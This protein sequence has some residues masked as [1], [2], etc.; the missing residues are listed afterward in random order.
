LL[1][2]YPLDDKKSSLL[3]ENGTPFWTHYGIRVD[4]EFRS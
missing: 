1:K 3:F 2:E 4:N